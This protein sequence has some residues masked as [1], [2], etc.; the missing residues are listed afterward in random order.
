MAST[1]TN[2]P[3]MLERVGRFLRQDLWILFRN[4]ALV[5]IGIILFVS[6][7]M[8]IILSLTDLLVSIC[9]FG[10]RY[11]VTLCK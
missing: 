11:F 7:V 5:V 1:Q 4:I 8:P 3:G 6:F 2:Q 10:Q 9:E